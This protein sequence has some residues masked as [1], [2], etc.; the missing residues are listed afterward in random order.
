MNKQQLDAAAT[1]ALQELSA[2]M[3]RETPGL[4]RSEASMVASVGYGVQI[5]PIRRIC[6]IISLGTDLYFF[7]LSSQEDRAN[8]AKDSNNFHSVV[9]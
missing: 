8:E 1:K 3:N 9:T 2:N 4:C 6:Y 7:I 5:L